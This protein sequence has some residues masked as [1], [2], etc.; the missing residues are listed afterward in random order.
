MNIFMM[1]IILNMIKIRTCIQRYV[2]NV[3]ININMKKCNI[4]KKIILNLLETFKDELMYFKIVVF[5]CH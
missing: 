4:M 2:F 5:S 1:K 3:D